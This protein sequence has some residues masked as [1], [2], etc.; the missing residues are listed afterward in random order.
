MDD[1]ALRTTIGVVDRVDADGM[2]LLHEVGSGKRGFVANTTPIFRMAQGYSNFVALRRDEVKR[3]TQ[4]ELK[5]ADEG[6][7]MIV[8]S[9]TTLAV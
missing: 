8:T 3:G 5:V 7:I 4:L 2:V 6:N 9:A 1:T